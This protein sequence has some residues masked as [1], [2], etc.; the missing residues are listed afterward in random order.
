[1]YKRVYNFLSIFFLFV[2]K[3]IKRT[4]KNFTDFN[5]EKNVFFK[6]KF[7]FSKTQHRK[8]NFWNHSSKVQN[9]NQTEI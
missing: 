5:N 8:S 4:F 7:N 1:M 2:Q 3:K 6:S 9:L